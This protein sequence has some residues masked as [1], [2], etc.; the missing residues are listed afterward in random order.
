MMIHALAALAIIAG[1]AVAPTAS[2]EDVN[3]CP[4]GMTGVVTA[5]T[6]CAFAE[7][8][9]AAWYAQPPGAVVTAYS[10]VTQGT[11]AMQC[12]PTVTDLWPEAQRCSGTNYYGA[13]LVVLISTPSGTPGGGQAGPVWEQP[14]VVAPS[15]GAG[16]DSPSLPFVDAPGFGCTWVNGYTK[17]NGTRVSGYWRC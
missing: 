14:V 5:D 7:N 3:T 6:S 13:N 1:L 8:V 10:P 11:Y 4:S 17:S 16:A 2:A 15:G 9:R 12:A